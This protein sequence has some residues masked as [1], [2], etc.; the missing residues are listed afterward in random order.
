MPSQCEL[1]P[2]HIAFY[3]HRYQI[4]SNGNSFV[5]NMFVCRCVNILIPAKRTWHSI[6]SQ[7]CYATGFD[8]WVEHFS[9]SYYSFVILVNVSGKYQFKCHEL[10]TQH[11]KIFE[12]ILFFLFFWTSNTLP[13]RS[14]PL[15]E[16]I[17]SGLMSL[18]WAG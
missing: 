16:G 10:N 4:T 13:C 12:P 7:N 9:P 15:A 2:T 17:G 3:G 18:K 8:A 14:G 1:Q 5:Y 6:W 11:P